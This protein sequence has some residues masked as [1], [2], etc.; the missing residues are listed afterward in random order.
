MTS[1]NNTSGLSNLYIPDFQAWSEFYE[2]R[3]DKNAKVGFGFKTEHE[4]IGH[5]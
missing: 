3:L 4:K 2:S 1:N 5:A